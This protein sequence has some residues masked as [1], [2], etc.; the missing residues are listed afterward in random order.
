MYN[1]NIKISNFS[2][3]IL[4]SEI[5]IIEIGYSGYHLCPISYKLIKEERI[6]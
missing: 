2:L 3:D 6:N 1:R 4:S 5:P